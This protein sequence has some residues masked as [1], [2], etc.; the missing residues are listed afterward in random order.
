MWR[1]AAVVVLV[2]LAGCSGFLGSDGGGPAETVTPAPIPETATERPVPVPQENG[3]VDLQRVLER[4]D[5]ALSGRSFHRRV[6]REGPRNTRDVWVDRDADIVRVRRTFGPLADDAVVTNGTLYR[7]VS[8][9]PN[10]DY[11]TSESDDSPPYVSTLSGVRLLDVFLSDYTY[12]RVGTVQRGGRTL[13]L[14]A[15]NDTDIPITAGDP[16]Q[17]VAVQSR[18]YVDR[19]GIVRYVD[20]YERHSDGTNSTV[21]MRVTT[22]TDRIAV[23]W[24]LADVG[25]YD[26]G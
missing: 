22:G 11:I 25:L 16:D 10:R 9:D 6:V 20:H 4:H 1:P 12:E 19:G 18:L 26:D 17:T 3:S 14:L 24:W 2:L 15:T 13:A 7:A 8:D 21:Q 23:P 5:A